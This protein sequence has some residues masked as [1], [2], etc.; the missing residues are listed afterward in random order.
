MYGL[1]WFV[2]PLDTNMGVEFDALVPEFVTAGAGIGRLRL[3]VRSESVA[4]PSWS[5]TTEM[6][7]SPGASRPLRAEALGRAVP[8]LPG[9]TRPGE[10]G[11]I[12]GG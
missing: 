1:A 8:P 5:R 4:G 2:A 11:G 10:R 9:G 6:I 3:A 12:A 7:E